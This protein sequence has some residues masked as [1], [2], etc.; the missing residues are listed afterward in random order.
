[1]VFVSNSEVG[2]SRKLYGFA[3]RLLSSG[4]AVFFARRQPCG[5]TPLFP[6]KNATAETLRP[7]KTKIFELEEAEKRRDTTVFQALRQTFTGNFV[8]QA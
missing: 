5:K 2:E 7:V 8:L 1:L 4:F 3:H 6:L